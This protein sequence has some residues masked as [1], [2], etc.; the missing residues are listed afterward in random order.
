[1][2]SHCSEPEDSSMNPLLIARTRDSSTGI[3]Y[4]YRSVWSAIISRYHPSLYRLR[5][6]LSSLSC[7]LRLLWQ[8][9]KSGTE[10]SYRSSWEGDSGEI[11]IFLKDFQEWLGKRGYKYY[12]MTFGFSISDLSEPSLEWFSLRWRNRLDNTENSF[13]ICTVSCIFFAVMSLYLQVV[14]KCHDLTSF[15]IYSKLYHRQ[16]KSL[17]RSVFYYIVS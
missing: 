12:G 3:G 15:L 13:S 5:Y 14:T 10:G 2:S 4:R 6:P 17:A 7:R 9:R 1:M 8:Y 16:E 11:I